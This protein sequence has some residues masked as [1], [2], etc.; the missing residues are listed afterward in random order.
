MATETVNSYL[1]GMRAILY[2]AMEREYVSQFKVKLIKAEKSIKETYTDSEL[3]KLLKKPPIKNGDFTEYRNWVMINYLLGTG[4]RS[5]TLR[6]MRI[7]DID[8]ESHEIALKKVKNKR[9]YTIPLSHTLERVLMEYLQYRKGNP[10]EYLFCT[11]YGEQITADGLTTIIGKYNIA[12]GVS[13]TSVH[14]FRHTFAKKWILNK[15]DIFRLQKILGH[16]SLEIVKEYVNMFGQDLQQDF[17]IFNPLD[18]LS[19]NREK[20]KIRLDKQ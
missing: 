13:K 6:E 2:F 7:G 18:N 1:R 4:N 12:R 5:R 16:K 15:G 14:L 8:F 10:D 20:N 11:Q 3:E 19:F 17:D 9:A